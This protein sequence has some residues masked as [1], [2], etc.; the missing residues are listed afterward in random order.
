MGQ[1]DLTV[2][3]KLCFGRRSRHFAR[4][5]AAPPTTMNR[6]PARCN[7]ASD[8]RAVDL[9]DELHKIWMTLLGGS[10]MRI[11]GSRR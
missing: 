11:R 4:L 10:S 5:A 8:E 1:V 6:T 3:K 9:F 7:S 2:A